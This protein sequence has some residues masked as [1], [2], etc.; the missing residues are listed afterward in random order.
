MLVLTV[1]RTQVYGA[2]WNDK[3]SLLAS[4]GADSKIRMWD[5]DERKEF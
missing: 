2:T 5:Y 3:Q 4:Y 1:L